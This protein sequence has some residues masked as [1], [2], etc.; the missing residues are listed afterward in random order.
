MRSSRSSG[1]RISA[2]C[3]P[4]CRRR[5]APCSAYFTLT[6]L[7][8]LCAPTSA[9]KMLPSR[10]AAMPEA[11]VPFSTA[12]RSAGSGMNPGERSVARVADHDA[13]QPALLGAGLAERGADIDRVV[14]A[15]EH[16]T[17]LAE[18]RPGGDEAA[19]LVEHLDAVVFTVGD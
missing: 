9:A 11:D 16:R 3:D 4:C 7:R 6:Y 2:S 15:H 8:R 12:S 5:E 14:A 10:S 1:S 17:R 19:L 13:A 18:L